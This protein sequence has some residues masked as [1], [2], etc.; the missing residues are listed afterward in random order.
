IAA[1]M[2]PWAYSVLDSYRSSLV[3]TRTRPPFDSS[4]AA[5]IPAIPPPRTIKSTLLSLCFTM[6]GYIIARPG[7]LRNNYCALEVTDQQ[8]ESIHHRGTEITEK[9]AL[10]RLVRITVG[11]HVDPLFLSLCVLRVLCRSL[12]NPSFIRRS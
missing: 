2:P 11:R 9:D 6:V 3:R 4:I 7:L 10:P 1:A 12:V 8:K 5:R